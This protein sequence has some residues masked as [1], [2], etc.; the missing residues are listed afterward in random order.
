MSLLKKLFSKKDLHEDS[1]HSSGNSL[2]P[3]SVIPATPTETNLS[4]ASQI[5]D[6]YLPLWL[7]HKQRQLLEV[8]IGSGTRIYQSMIIALDIERGLLW[9]DD[10]FPQQRTLDIGDEL[11]IRHHRNGEQ[12]LIRTPILAF[13]S[14]YGA[15]GIAILL[16]EN[17]S[18]SPRRSHP[19]F[20]SVGDSPT[21]VKIRTL[22][23][24]PSF[25]TLQDISAGGLRV[26]IAGNM[27]PHLRHGIQ[28]PLCEFS[29][30]DDLQVRCRARVCAFRITRSPYRCTQISLE[31]VDLPEPKRHAIHQLLQRT[32]SGAPIN[33]YAA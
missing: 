2:I 10:L 15:A 28:L 29:L 18:Y 24:E 13:G 3:S 11:V 7:L 25:G 21:M 20:N 33:F 9:L 8:K 1:G 27:L 6:H 19:R 22:G 26:N 23:Q 32:Q 12:L 30:G 16:P 4:L 14:C 31:F 17:A 5:P